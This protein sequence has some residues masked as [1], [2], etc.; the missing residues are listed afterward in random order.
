MKRKN[1][2][3]IYLTEFLILT[4]GYI[5]LTT[6]GAGFLALPPYAL[7]DP[8][9]LLL[10]FAFTVPVLIGSGLGKDLFRVFKPGKSSLVNLKRTL[11]AVKLMQR[12]ILYTGCILIT[13]SALVTLY[14][15]AENKQAPLPAQLFVTILPAIYMV[16]LELLLA[17]LYTETKLAILD[18]MG[19]DE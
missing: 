7:F 8:P 18:Y 5:L 12:Q 15:V 16:V 19:R 11:E 17:P 14:A 13:F 3:L 10:F 2:F 1:L 4:A 6:R 9:T